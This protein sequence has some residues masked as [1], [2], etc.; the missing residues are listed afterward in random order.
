MLLALCSLLPCYALCCPSKTHATPAAEAQVGLAKGRGLLL[1]AEM[2][3]KGTLAQG[4]PL[5]AVVA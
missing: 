5:P 4:A 1:L 3:S 2:S